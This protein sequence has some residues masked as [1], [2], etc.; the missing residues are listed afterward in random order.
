MLLL[1]IAGVS[2]L[3]QRRSRL[4]PLHPVLGSKK[5]GELKSPYPDFALLGAALNARS[6][7]QWGT[8]GRRMP[9]GRGERGGGRS[10]ALPCLP[11]RWPGSLGAKQATLGLWPLWPLADSSRY[12][13]RAWRWQRVTGMPGSLSPAVCPATHAIANVTGRRS[14]HHSGHCRVKDRV[15]AG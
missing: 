11:W 1:V 2:A 12:S 13:S 7:L 3:R 4:P 6:Q 8:Q 9:R 10:Q 15:S 5:D 14:C